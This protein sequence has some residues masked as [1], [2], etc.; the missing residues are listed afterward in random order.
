MRPFSMPVATVA[1]L[2]VF[3]VCP[4]ALS[5]DAVELTDGAVIRGELVAHRQRRQDSLLILQ[6][7]F[8]IVGTFDV[9][10]KVTGKAYDLARGR[11]RS[12]P[13][14]TRRGRNANARP[15][16]LGVIHL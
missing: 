16:A 8:G 5:L 15:H 3:L 13:A 14:I 11:Q 2:L 7:G 6:F 12:R 4:P 1:A 9:R 10:A